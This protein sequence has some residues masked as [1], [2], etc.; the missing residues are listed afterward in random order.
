MA[1]DV[2]FNEPLKGGEAAA[3]SEKTMRVQQLIVKHQLGLRAFILS[4]EPNFTDAE[5]LLQEVFLVITRKA[6]EFQEGTNFFAWGCTIAWFILM[7]LMCIRAQS[8]ALLDVC[9]VALCAVE[10]KNKLDDVLM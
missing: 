9:I 3:L 5:D 8:N 10:Y 6:N 7:E 1:D 2:I 4:L